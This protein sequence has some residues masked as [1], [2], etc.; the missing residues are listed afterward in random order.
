MCVIIYK[1]EGVAIPS[2][3][4]LDKAQSANPHGCGFCTPTKSYKGLSYNQFLKGLREVDPSEPLLI[5][6]RLA[7]HGSVKKSNCHPFYE[8][9]TDTQ[10]MH[11]GILYAINPDRDKT[12]SECAFRGFINP[13]VE[14]FGLHSVEVKDVV[15]R[16][17]GASKFALM[18]GG[19]VL[20]FGEF[21]LRGDLYLSNLRFIY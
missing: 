18:Q 11:N 12:D 1:P 19:E 9:Q 21:I 15:G 16:I 20:L 13:I 17:I 7:T 4:L 14:C 3:A 8:N 10:F 6:F 5:H 2:R